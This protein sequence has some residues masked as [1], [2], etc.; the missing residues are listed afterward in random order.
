MFENSPFGYDKYDI[1][2]GL[3]QPIIINHND[4]NVT[5]IQ[6]FS[7]LVVP[8][9]VASVPQFLDD[10][11][12]GVQVSCPTQEPLVKEWD[13]LYCLD[14]GVGTENNESRVRDGR[15]DY[16]LHSLVSMYNV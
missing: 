3:W 10:S 13:V 2:M 1:S 6:G 15:S 12:L 16:N 4:V 5:A 7:H 8:V 11:V 14:L 9:V